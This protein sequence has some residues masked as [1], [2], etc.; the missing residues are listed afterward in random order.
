[1]S[2]Q[3]GLFDARD[4]DFEG[5]SMGFLVDSVCI[6][7]SGLFFGSSP[8]TPFVGRYLPLLSLTPALTAR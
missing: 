2:K 6:S 4:G 1:M 3:A 5:S 8:C 7:L